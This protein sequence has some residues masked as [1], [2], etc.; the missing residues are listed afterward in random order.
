MIQNDS[1]TL[2]VSC[3]PE[4]QC[5]SKIKELRG[6]QNSLGIRWPLNH[7]DETL[8]ENI[9]NEL[10][11]SSKSQTSPMPLQLSERQRSSSTR[12]TQWF[13]GASRTSN[14]CNTVAVKGLEP[15]VGVF[16]AACEPCF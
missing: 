7:E 9:T 13:Q 14:P 2:L 15:F 4:P 11:N 3:D 10:T 8:L 1:S 6:R 16:P 5:L 12:P